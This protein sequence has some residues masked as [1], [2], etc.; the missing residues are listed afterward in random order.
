MQ[1]KMQKTACGKPGQPE[2]RVQRKVVVGKEKSKAELDE[3]AGH[4][5][6]QAVLRG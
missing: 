3:S 1:I 6:T 4:R 5:Q 2:R